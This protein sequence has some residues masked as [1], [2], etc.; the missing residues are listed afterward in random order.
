[1]RM[2][3]PLTP[4]NVLTFDETQ[5]LRSINVNEDWLFEYVLAMYGVMED[6]RIANREDHMYE[7]LAGD[8]GDALMANEPDVFSNEAQD[9]FA[10]QFDKLF[11][12]MKKVIDQ[13]RP[14]V[15]SVSRGLPDKPV[16]VITFEP[17]IVP[18]PRRPTPAPQS[19]IP[20][21]SSLLTFHLEDPMPNWLVAKGMWEESAL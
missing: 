13:I 17:F 20:Y 15:D 16:E 1:M 3:V 7:Q 9:R 10:K 14:F 4:R 19:E 2:I 12:L 18:N 5:F 6:L 11:H 8:L 21:R